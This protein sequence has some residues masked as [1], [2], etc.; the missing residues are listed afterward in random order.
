[1]RKLVSE[2]GMFYTQ[3]ECKVEDKVFSTTVYLADTDS[4]DAWVQVSAEIKEEFEKKKKEL[5][6]EI[7]SQIAAGAI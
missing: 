3:K 6:D 2:N 1:M 4:E 7:R 5:M